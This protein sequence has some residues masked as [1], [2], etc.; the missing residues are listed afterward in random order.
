MLSS[1]VYTQRPK[2]SAKSSETVAPARGVVH[3]TSVF[4]GTRL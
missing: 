1:L 2:P 4:M 3:V